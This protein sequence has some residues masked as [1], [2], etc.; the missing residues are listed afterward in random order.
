MMF[1][2][3][4][5]AILRAL[6]VFLMVALA[7]ATQ[8]EEAPKPAESAKPA[9]S[10]KPEGSTRPAAGNKAAVGA[11]PS[12]ATRLDENGKPVSTPNVPPANLRKNTLEVTPLAE[13]DWQPGCGCRFYKP[14]DLRESGPLLLRLDDRRMARIRIEDKPESLRLV[15]ER[16][17]LRKPPAI[18]AHDRMMIKF[19]GAQSSASFSG[20]A[21][22]NCPKFNDA[23]KSVTYQGVLTVAQA[24]RHGAFPVWGLCGCEA[25][26]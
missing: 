9:G 19:K 3:P 12:P 21:E 23:C 22:R 17:V 10:T 1:A 15:D 14:T 8:A 4:R 13:S 20:S 2:L 24:G 5:L 25:K 16:H 7:P 6:S 18:L 26:P 11:T